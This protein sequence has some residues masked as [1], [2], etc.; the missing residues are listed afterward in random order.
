[1]GEVLLTP[2]DLI[3][4]CENCGLVVEEGIS[5]TPNVAEY[6]CNECGKTVESVKAI[7]KPRK[8]N[9]DG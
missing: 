2:G 4:N 8:V 6:K 5:P 9:I 3:A 1:M 7:Q